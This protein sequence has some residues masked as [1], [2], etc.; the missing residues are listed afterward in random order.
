MRKMRVLHILPNFGP[1]GA[2]RM[3]THLLL[4]IDRGRFEVAAVV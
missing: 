4:H 3:V 2:E 1:G